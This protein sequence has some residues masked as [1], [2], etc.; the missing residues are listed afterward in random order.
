[1]ENGSR[2]VN[3]LVGQDLPE[4]AC[5]GFTITRT[6]A[7]GTRNSEGQSVGRPQG[8]PL[9]LSLE[10]RATTNFVANRVLLGACFRLEGSFTNRQ[11]ASRLQ[12]VTLKPTGIHQRR[13]KGFQ[14]GRAGGK[15]LDSGQDARVEGPVYDK[16]ESKREQVQALRADSLAQCLAQCGREPGRNGGYCKLLSA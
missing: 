13:A 6:S 9:T 11:V 8:E 14:P 15:E 1:V 4:Y 10:F 12:V 7:L 2:Q 3:L 16:R 5:L